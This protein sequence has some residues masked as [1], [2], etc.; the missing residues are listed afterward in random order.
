MLSLPMMELLSAGSRE[1]IYVNGVDVTST[2]D[3]DILGTAGNISPTHID[4]AE[5]FVSPSEILNGK[6]D[7]MRFYNRVLTSA[8]ALQLYRAGK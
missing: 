4:I 5:S 6:L 2:G 3:V 7:E 1:K 8:E